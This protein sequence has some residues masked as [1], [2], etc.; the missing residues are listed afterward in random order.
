VIGVGGTGED[1]YYVFD[2]SGENKLAFTG[3]NKKIEIFEGSYVLT[4]NGSTAT[5]SVRPGE[6]TVV[7]AGSLVV[8]GDEKMLYEVYDEAG[9]TNLNFKHVGGA[10]ELFPGSYT[11]VCGGGKTTAVVKAGERTEVTPQ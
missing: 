6:E 11:V 7:G 10:M 3:T 2:E 4:L 1:L 9:E 5:A 8:S